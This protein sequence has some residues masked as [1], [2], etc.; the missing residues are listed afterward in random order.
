[1]R[2]L[3]NGDIDVQICTLM[4]IAINVEK[5]GEDG[6][7]DQDELMENIK[8]IKSTDP[9]FQAALDRLNSA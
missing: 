3:N 8:T 2:F 6:L 9:R 4:A 1:M 5:F 7:T